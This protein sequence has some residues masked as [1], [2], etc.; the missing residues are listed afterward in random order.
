MCTNVADLRGGVAFNIVPTRAEL[1]WS[2][3]PPPGT[4]LESVQAEMA[5]LVP[6]GVQLRTTLSNPAFATRDL[7]AFR[8][9]LQF[10]DPTDLGFWTEAAM[11]A[12]AGVNAI[13][14]GPG[15]IAFAH[16][17]DERVPI[18]QLEAA[19]AAFVE[20]FRGSV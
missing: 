2:V 20:M 8:P 11:L 3:R 16:A 17:P 1:L 10:D 12:E 9:L 6:P 14:F 13:V 7:E 18:D 19:R 5:A 15:D 4:S